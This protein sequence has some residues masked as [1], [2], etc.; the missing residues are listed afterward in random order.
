LCACG[1]AL[2][3]SDRFAKSF[4]YEL[5]L[6]LQTVSLAAPGA[7]WQSLEGGLDLGEFAAAS[8]SAVGDS[9][10]TVVRIDPARFRLMLL[11]VVDLALP[12][13]LG[14][15]AWTS[16][17]QLSAAINGGMF[18]RDRRTTTGYARIGKTRINP[19]WKPTYQAF[20]A[21]DP[22][23]R[24]LPAATILDPECDDVKGME[25]HYRTV[26]QSI[27]MVDCKGVNRWAKALN[28]W[29]TS[30]LAIDGAHRILFIHARSPWPV[31]D[32]IENLLALPLDIKRAMYLEGGPEASLSL[33]TAGKSFVQVGSW[34]TGFNEND[35]NHAFWP[36]PNVIGA[37][38][39]TDKRN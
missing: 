18:E 33:A 19:T 5:R 20:L 15:D 9:R 36:L 27:R 3:C 29:S 24:R 2:L 12:D 35:D 14:I 38:R 13:A 31:H 17:Y 34:E 26:L 10:V 37:R 11:S 7:Q 30:A 1:L 25:M 22:D 4:G 21:L 28:A 39:A 23:D 6:P 32:L 16:R 8:A